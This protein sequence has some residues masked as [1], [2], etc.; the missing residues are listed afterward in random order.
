MGRHA[1]FSS[2]PGFCVAQR[3]DR[4]WARGLDGMRLPGCSEVVTKR[5]SGSFTRAG[6]LTRRRR[7]E[8]EPRFGQTWAK[9]ASRRA[10]VAGVARIAG[11]PAV[12]GPLPDIA[13]NIVE[14]PG[15]KESPIGDQ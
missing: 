13:V 2:A 6:H 10:T 8:I 12:L 7:R 1:S 9:P 14:A 4:R 15:F 3:Q 11:I 5:G